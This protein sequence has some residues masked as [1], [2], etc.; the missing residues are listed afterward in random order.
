MGPPLQ[1][2]LPPLNQWPLASG[3]LQFVAELGAELKKA[4]CSSQLPSQLLLLQ[5]LVDNTL[6]VR[7]PAAA[8]QASRVAALRAQ[9]QASIATLSAVPPR[10]LVA[11]ALTHERAFDLVEATRCLELAIAVSPEGWPASVDGIDALTRLAKQRSDCGWQCYAAAHGLPTVA[12]AKPPPASCSLAAGEEHIRASVALCDEALRLAPS[13]ARAH[14]AAALCGGRAALFTADVRARVALCN[15]IRVLAERAL[16]LDPH[17]DA[18]HHVLGRWHWEIA[19]L[20]PVVKV[21]LRHVLGGD[22]GGSHAAALEHFQA[23]ATL[24]PHRLTHKAEHGKALIKL[25]RRREGLTQ[26]RAALSCPVE[27]VNAES[28]RLHAEALL[29]RMRR[30]DRRAAREERRALI[31]EKRAAARAVKEEAKRAKRAA[32]ESR[33]GRW[34]SLRVLRVLRTGGKEKDNAKAGNT[35]ATA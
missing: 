14:M 32:R 35:A 24:A 8:P 5:T 15:R 7:R 2:Q 18:A 1:L 29:A 25:G 19:S 13:S 9:H 3:P 34:L 26:L 28:G 12:G 27:D 11:E 16:A 20:N 6:H 22:T 4:F 23:A 21:L 33:G 10:K 17:E 31:T 30:I